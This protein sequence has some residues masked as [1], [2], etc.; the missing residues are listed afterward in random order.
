LL[1]QRGAF[2]VSD[3]YKLAYA[4]QTLG[5]QAVAGGTLAGSCNCPMLSQYKNAVHQQLTKQLMAVS[6]S[7]AC[8]L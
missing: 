7:F 5:N 4:L 8:V 1:G 3:N 2:L 6:N